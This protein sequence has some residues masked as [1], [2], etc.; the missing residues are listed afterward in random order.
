[1]YSD[2]SPDTPIEAVT[3]KGFGVSPVHFQKF[4]SP[5]PPRTI[6]FL[7]ASAAAVA[8]GGKLKIT[9]A[10]LC[11]CVCVFCVVRRRHTKNARWM[12]ICY[13][14]R[15]DSSRHSLCISFA[16]SEAFSFSLYYFVRSVFCFVLF[17][18]ERRRNK[19]FSRLKACR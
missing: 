12:R 18:T 6:V 11:A 10:H 3:M 19:T 1:M 4:L 2:G 16:L 13:L 15:K 9:H 7:F 14:M 8:G 17:G 5:P